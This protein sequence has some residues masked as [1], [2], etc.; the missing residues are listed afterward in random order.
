MKLTKMQQAVYSALDVVPAWPGQIAQRAGIR[1]ISPSETAAKFCRHLVKMG[2]AKRTGS[3]MH[4]KW[5][6]EVA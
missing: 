2:L 5:H 3:S 4:P 1:T 6:R